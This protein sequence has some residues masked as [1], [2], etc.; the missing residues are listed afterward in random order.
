[1]GNPIVDRV[2]NTEGIILIIPAMD[3][4]HIYPLKPKYKPI[5]IAQRT[6]IFRKTLSPRYIVILFTTVSMVSNTIGRHNEIENNP[7]IL[8][9]SIEPSHCLP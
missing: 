2:V 5:G 9:I 1:M 8:N 6:K 7:N 4:A 3:I